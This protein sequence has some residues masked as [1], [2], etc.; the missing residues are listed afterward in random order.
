MWLVSQQLSQSEFFFLPMLSLIQSEFNR[1][2][3]K[4]ESQDASVPG[5]PPLSSASRWASLYSELV[6]P[7]LIWE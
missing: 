1:K 7:S 3:N 2:S 4:L 6:F 5:F